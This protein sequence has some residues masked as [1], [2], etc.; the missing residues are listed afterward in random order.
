[1]SFD[2]AWCCEA[3]SAILFRIKDFHEH[4]LSLS[5]GDPRSKL[6][7]VVVS[8]KSV[9]TSL[10]FILQSGVEIVVRCAT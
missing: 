1:M 5:L 6:T 8:K 10:P 4:G 9:S 7:G 2:T 3:M